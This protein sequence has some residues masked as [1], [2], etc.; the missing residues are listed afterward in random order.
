MLREEKISRASATCRPGNRCESKNSLKE[1]LAWARNE[2]KT[3]GAHEARINSEWLLTELTG[4]D[5]V[6][7][8][9]A[10]GQVLSGPKV[11]KFRTLVAQRKRGV[12]FS[13][14][15]GKASFWN[16]VLEVG[17]GCLIPRPETEILVEQFIKNTDFDSENSF[18]FLDLGAGSGAIGI[19][20]LRQYPK[21]YATF[22]DVSVSALRFVRRNLK[23]Y[24]LSGRAEV[25]RANLFN[26]F[27][28]RKWDAIVSNPPYLSKGDWK[29]AGPEILKEPREALDGGEDG[30][31]FYRR[32]IAEAARHLNVRGWLALEVGIRQAHKVMGWLAQ[33]GFESVNCFKDLRGIDRVIIARAGSYG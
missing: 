24:D 29:K 3:L 30:F 26:A 8:Y 11:K 16:E 33:N 19:A 7:F 4:F 17:S 23:R 18:C 25:V 6:A 20:L 28:N 22:S 21:G 15:T 32:I 14:L 5:R 27:E 31:C 2:L 9:L 13:Y 10:A 12:P 1:L